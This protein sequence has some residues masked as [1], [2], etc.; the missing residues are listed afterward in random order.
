[1]NAAPAA[2]PAPPQGTRAHVA[3]LM[4]YWR[5]HWRFG[6]FL[7]ALTLLSTAVTVAWPLVLQRWLDRLETHA[8]GQKAPVRRC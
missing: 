7:V 1:M 4:R 8:A 6:A 2:A 5:P 3:W